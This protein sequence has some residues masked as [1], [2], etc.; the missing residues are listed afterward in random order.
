MTHVMGQIAYKSNL[1]GKSYSHTK[2]LTLL[3]SYILDEYY[4][5]S[6]R[7]LLCSDLLS[8]AFVF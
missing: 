7:T 3:E 4:A 8:S 1:K 5:L 6:V 2:F